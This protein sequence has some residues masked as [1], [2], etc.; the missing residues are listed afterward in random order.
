[1]TQWNDVG[2]QNGILN[3]KIHIELSSWL[4]LGEVAFTS[5]LFSVQ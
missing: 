1:M 3:S 2:V 4:L 5:T